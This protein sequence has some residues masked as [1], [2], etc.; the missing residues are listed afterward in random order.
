MAIK[1]ELMRVISTYYPKLDFF[2][3]FTN[4]FKIKSFFRYK[5]RLDASLCSNVVYNYTCPNCQA[6]YLGISSRHLVTRA[7]EHMGVSARTWKKVSCP[8]FSAIREHIERNNSSR[9]HANAPECSV[10]L[11]DFK[12]EARAR[13]PSDLP[14]LEAILISEKRPD[15]NHRAE[16]LYIF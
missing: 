13:Y 8:K 15:L 7:T 4:N 3:I 14:I 11:K 10:S 16:G 9:T 6:G 2:P 5:D 1:R 12:I